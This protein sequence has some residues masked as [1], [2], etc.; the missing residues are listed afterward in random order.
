MDLYGVAFNRSCRVILNHGGFLITALHP[1]KVT[2]NSPGGNAEQ[3]RRHVLVAARMLQR[4]IDRLPLE[5]A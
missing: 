1:F 2:V 3:P 5:F 4:N